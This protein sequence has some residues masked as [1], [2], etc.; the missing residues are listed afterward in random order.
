MKIEAYKQN[1]SY[2]ARTIEIHKDSQGNFTLYCIPSVG[3]TYTL[4]GAYRTLE[5]A[6]EAVQRLDCVFGFTKI[7]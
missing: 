3:H 5:E 1:R 6:Q 7:V 2:Q 4:D